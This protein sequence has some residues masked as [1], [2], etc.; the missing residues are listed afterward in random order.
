MSSQ[1][2]MCWRSGFQRSTIENGGEP[3]W[4]LPGPGQVLSPAKTSLKSVKIAVNA[5]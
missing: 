3:D 5:S 4:T 1:R 2:P